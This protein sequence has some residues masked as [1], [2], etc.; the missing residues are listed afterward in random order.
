MSTERKKQALSIL[1][2]NKTRYDLVFLFIF[3]NR[4]IKASQSAN[5]L[6]SGRSAVGSAHG[7]GP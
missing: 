2:M 4:L 3:Y 5:I 7:S 1:K 6:L